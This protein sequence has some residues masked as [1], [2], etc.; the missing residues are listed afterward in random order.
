MGQTITKK[1]DLT[2]QALEWVC[3]Y[4]HSEEDGHHLVPLQIIGASSFEEH[5]C[6]VKKQH[7]IP[8][9]HHIQDQV[10]G[11]FN[12]RWVKSQITGRHPGTIVSIQPQLGQ[13]IWE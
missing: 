10:E 6:L 1:P 5:V 9:A 13:Q 4:Q 8:L 2:D 7:G 12:A 11:I 3:S